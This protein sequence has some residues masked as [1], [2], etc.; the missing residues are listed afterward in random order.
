MSVRFVKCSTPGLRQIQSPKSVFGSRKRD[1]NAFQK[2]PLHL[3]VMIMAIPY[4]VRQRIVL[5]PIDRGS[6]FVSP[7]R[8]SVIDDGL[9]LATLV[10]RRICWLVV[11]ELGDAVVR[12]WVDERIHRQR[13]HLEKTELK[14]PTSPVRVK[15][16]KSKHGDKL[17]WIGTV[18]TRKWWR[19][20]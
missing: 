3:K 14:W 10:V 6:D 11:G 1:E 16:L 20:G 8:R 4:W 2:L 12:K 5:S 7:V 18:R 17:T 13:S 9:K 19:S 15:R